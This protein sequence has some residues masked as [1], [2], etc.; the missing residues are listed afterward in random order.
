MG[1]DFNQN[2]GSYPFPPPFVYMPPNIPPWGFGGPFP[3]Y[4]PPGFVPQPNQWIA[5]GGQQ[6]QFGD[7]SKGKNL[8]KSFPKK[9]GKEVSVPNTNMVPMSQL[10]YVDTICGCCGDPGHTKTEYTKAQICFICKASNHVVE[11]CPVL[12]RPHQV[13]RY[14]GSSATGW[15]FYHIEMPEVTSNPVSTTRN[16]GIV[17]VEEGSIAR[18]ELAQ[19]F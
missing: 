3:P 17:T 11:G 14:V 16:F 1:F 9:K 19:E 6:S 10:N 7:S 18:E 8:G 13:S 15:G 2:Q 5:T 12:K 4:P